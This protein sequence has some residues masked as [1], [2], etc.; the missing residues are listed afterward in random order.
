MIAPTEPTVKMSSGVGSFVLAWRWAARKISFCWPRFTASSS[1]AML[2]SRPTKSCDTM[3]GNTM[4]SRSGRSGIAPRASALG[5]PSFLK[6][7]GAPQAS[8]ASLA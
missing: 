7:I 5:R 1:A 4:M 8:S 3:C 6:N 2:R